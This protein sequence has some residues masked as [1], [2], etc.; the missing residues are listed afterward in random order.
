MS[1]GGA[2]SD[3]WVRIV[4]SVLGLPLERMESEAG[5]AFGAALLAGVREG[6]FADA[7]RRSR[8]ASA[9]TT[10]SNRS[11]AGSRPYAEGYERFVELYPRLASR[12]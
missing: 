11:P 3:I 1:G 7:G 9:S 6:V 2:R 5:A 4:A 10:A 8:A 12:P